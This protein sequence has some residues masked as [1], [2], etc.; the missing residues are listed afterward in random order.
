MARE[1]GD[2]EVLSEPLKVLAEIYLASDRLEQAHEVAQEALELRIA[3]FQADIP[4]FIET[5]GALAIARGEVA[6]GVRPVSA[7]RT[8]KGRSDQSPETPEEKARQPLINSARLA[9]GGAFDSEWREGENLS[10]ARAL[11]LARQTT[12]TVRSD[13]G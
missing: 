13:S 11:D 3:A 5:I 2:E 7:A 10:E 4:D 9:I 1:L 12:R 8:A 6:T